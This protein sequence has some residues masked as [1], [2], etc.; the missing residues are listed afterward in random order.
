MRAELPRVTNAVV[1]G[2]GFIGLEA[3]AVLTRSGKNVVLL[4]ALDRVMARVSGWPV[5]SFFEAEHRAHGVRQGWA[6]PSKR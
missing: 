3:A 4:E 1:V 2:G 5:S 6:W